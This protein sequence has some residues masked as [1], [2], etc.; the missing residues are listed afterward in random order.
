ML[1]WHPHF[2]TSG[3]CLRKMSLQP[4]HLFGGDQK[5]RVE[6]VFHVRSDLWNQD[7]VGNIPG[8]IRSTLVVMSWKSSWRKESKVVAWP[9]TTLWRKLGIFR[10][11]HATWGSV[12]R[13]NV[14]RGTKG[15]KH[16]AEELSTQGKPAAQS[17]VI[18]CR[19]GPKVPRVARCSLMPLAWFLRGRSGVLVFLR[20]Q[21][22][23]D[24]IVVRRVTLAF[25]S[26]TIE[27]SE[28]SV[29]PKA[30]CETV[31]IL[32]CSC[33]NLFFFHSQHSPHM[34]LRRVVKAAIQMCGQM[35][36]RVCKAI[37]S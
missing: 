5:S 24:P 7:K 33:V 25:D 31:E 37:A 12:C 27:A 17:A 4:G 14:Y 32:W 28:I 23:V 36:S 34:S 10:Q 2:S 8:K 1:I 22:D 16:W 19:S 21:E 30:D 18:A 13:S 35:S 15:N 6:I 26:R 29:E 20:L 11:W 3:I 9:N